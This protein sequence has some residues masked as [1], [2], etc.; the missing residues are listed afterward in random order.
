MGNE[1][2]TVTCA[3]CGRSLESYERFCAVCGRP[4]PEAPPPGEWPGSPAPPRYAS[5]PGPGSPPPPPVPQPP[6]AESPQQP[7][8]GYQPPQPPPGY[9]PPYRPPEPAGYQPQYQ[10]AQ[11][12]AGY[13]PPPGQ[14]YVPAYPPGL[15]AQPRG[16]GMAIVSL[17]LGILSL[18]AWLFWPLGLL[19]SIPGLV[20]GI[21]G[22]RSPSRGLAIGGIVTSSVGLGLS[23]V[24]IIL[25]IILAIRQ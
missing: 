1:P 23:L 5:P 16:S 14:P 6:A 8:G 20:L 12:P 9:Q 13:Q 19:V 7:P 2:G 21:I 17:V 10:S 25:G 15:A 24:N 4:R 18:L 11:S 22:R 3:G